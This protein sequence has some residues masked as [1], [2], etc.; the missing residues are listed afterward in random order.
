[1]DTAIAALVALAVFCISVGLYWSEPEPT[2]PSDER[3]N[4]AMG[5]Y[6]HRPPGF[7]EP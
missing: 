1:M 5:H 6:D 7:Y 4:R 3:I 2:E